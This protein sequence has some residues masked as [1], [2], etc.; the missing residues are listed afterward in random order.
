MNSASLVEDFNQVFKFTSVEGSVNEYVIG[1]K[2]TPSST[3]KGMTPDDWD[4]FE[5]DI[6]DAFEQ[7]P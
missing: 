1:S 5:K 3:E 2:R 4:K 7:V 6:E